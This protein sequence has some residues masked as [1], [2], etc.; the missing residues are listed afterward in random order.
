MN[1]AER[2][3]Q[4]RDAKPATVIGY[5]H[6]EDVSASFAYSLCRLMLY[7]TA[8]T[9]MPPYLLA[10]RTPAGQLVENRNTVVAHFLESGAEWLLFVDSDMGFPADALERLLAVASVERPIV[11]GLCFGLWV[12]NAHFDDA[13]QACSWRSFPTIYSFV[14]TDDTVGFTAA[15]A[16]PDDDVVE[17]S[18]TGAAFFVA[19]RSV[20]E[21][22][23][24]GWFEPVT[25]P[26]GNV[27]FSEDLSFF[28]RAAAAG[29]GCAVH[30]GVR[31]SHAKGVFLTAEQYMV[32]EVGRACVAP[33]GSPKVDPEA[34]AE[35]IRVAAR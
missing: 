27:R 19:H 10:Q 2:R 29:Y 9:G 35:V 1:R 13:T 15:S 31:T 33:D 4:A 24:G 22:I 18:A 7:E 17:C 3:R 14:E 6:P 11:G 12:D 32:Q 8:R 28:I 25:H 20:Y 16:F 5:L 30:T 21:A 23:G 34:L 26:K